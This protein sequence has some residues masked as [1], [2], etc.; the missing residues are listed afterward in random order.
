MRWASS[1]WRGAC[2]LCFWRT[3]FLPLLQT[4]VEFLNEQM[5]STEVLAVEVKRHS[6]E[7]M[8]TLVSRVIGRTSTARQT[9]A[10]GPKRDWDEESVL[11]EIRES[12]GDA[13]AIG[14]ADPYLGKG[15]PNDQVARRAAGR[16]RRVSGGARDGDIRGP[17][18]IDSVGRFWLSITNEMAK[19]HPFDDRERRAEFL[20]RLD[21]IPGV[22]L[23][24]E[25]VD[26]SWRGMPLDPLIHETAR[27][28]FFD[29]IEWCWSTGKGAS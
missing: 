12:K 23:A 11:A 28:E 19:L 26:K 2:G 14:R 3:R 27:H 4:I 9:K 17:F 7:G 22:T 1:R 29:A 10:A 16:L 20:A 13:C 24:P 8:S 5:R 15:P 6:G 18:G 21:A 25:Y